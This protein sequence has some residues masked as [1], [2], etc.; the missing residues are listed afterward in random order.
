MS[1]KITV[2][3][4]IILSISIFSNISQREKI[5]GL[6]AIYKHNLS[7]SHDS[8]KYLTNRYNQTVAEKK[9]YEI[10]LGDVKSLNDSLQNLIKSYQPKTIVHWRTKLVYKDTIHIKYD[11]IFLNKFTIPFR[12]KSKWLSIKGM[13]S[14]F[15]IDLN[16]IEINNT[17]SLVVGYKKDGFFSRP[18]ANVSIV[19][20]NPYITHS[21]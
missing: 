10:S 2:I 3:L 20:S 1:N 13:S 9:A 14:N 4:L 11:T 6:K 7:V 19:N 15:G 17:Q 16:K 21:H 12:Y 8:I 18:Y 5:D